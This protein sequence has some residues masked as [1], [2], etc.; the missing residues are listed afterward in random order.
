MHKGE[1]KYCGAGLDAG[2]KGAILSNCLTPA[3]RVCRWHPA[4]GRSEDAP[5][6]GSGGSEYGYRVE[7][8]RAS[9]EA[10]KVWRLCPA[11]YAGFFIGSEPHRE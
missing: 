8:C 3:E 7:T 2:A 10:A 1:E 4:I 5:L 6:H 11:L 9:R